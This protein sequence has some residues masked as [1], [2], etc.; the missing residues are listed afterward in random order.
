MCISFA[1]TGCTATDQVRAPADSS[2]IPTTSGYTAVVT[3]PDTTSMTSTDLCITSVVRSLQ[4]LPNL[5]GEEQAALDAV[6]AIPNFESSNVG[7]GFYRELAERDLAS[8]TQT[9]ADMP[10]TVCNQ[11]RN[12][13][14]RATCVDYA[15][16][17]PGGTPLEFQYETA[18]RL[19]DMMPTG[20][21]GLEGSAELQYYQAVR[22]AN[23]GMVGLL[24]ACATP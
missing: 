22:S 6:L 12:P 19:R 3:E 10:R 24:L 17:M 18:R 23:A 11:P 7:L 21:A 5:I 14:R 16:D 8:L 9:L 20:L 1:M 15:V 13:Q 2:Q 4:R